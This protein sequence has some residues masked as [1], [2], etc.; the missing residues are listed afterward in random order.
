MNNTVVRKIDDPDAVTGTVLA[1]FDLK[2]IKKDNPDF[3]RKNPMFSL[4]DN[5]SKKTLLRKTLK[6]DQYPQD[7]KYPW[8]YLGKTRFSAKNLLIFH[9][10]WWLSQDVGSSV[11]DPLEPNAEYEVHVSVKLRP[12]RLM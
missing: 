4:Y 7:E 10:S 5:L 3:H 6:P 8:Y 1:L 12:D 9:W 11:F 2:A